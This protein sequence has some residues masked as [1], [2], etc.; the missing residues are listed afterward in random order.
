MKA[1]SLTRLL[2]MCITFIAAG[3][4]ARGPTETADDSCIDPVTIGG[5][6]RSLSVGDTVTYVAVRQPCA[7]ADIVPVFQW[8][9]DGPSLLTLVPR[10]D[11]SVLITAISPGTTSVSLVAQ[12]VGKEPSVFET[13]S[14][15]IREQM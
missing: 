13:V 11:S 6:D 4:C 7:I 1:T 9:L 10:S 8:R 15:A 2:V 5:Q 14:I 3:D 12:W